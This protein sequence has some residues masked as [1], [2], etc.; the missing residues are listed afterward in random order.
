MSGY[1]RQSVIALD[2]YDPEERALRALIFEI[3]RKMKRKD[4]WRRYR[5]QAWQRLVEIGNQ[6]EE[7]QWR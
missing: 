6:T 3:E 7:N 5:R 1:Q 2:R 4:S